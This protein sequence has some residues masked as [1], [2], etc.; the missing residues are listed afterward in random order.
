MSPTDS[1]KDRDRSL[2][3]S[4]P[5][6]GD[7]PTSAMQHKHGND[8]SDTNMQ[9]PQPAK[10]RHNKHW[11]LA[12]IEWHDIDCETARCNITT[13][14]V[15]TAASFVETAADLYTANLVEHFTDPTARHWLRNYWQPEELQHGLAL[16]TYVETVWPEL[17]W[18]THYHNFFAEYSQLCTM[19]EL[20]DSP[21]LEMVA[22][23]VVEAGT[24][25][26]YAALQN[27]SDDPVLKKITGLISRDEV[28]HYNH[29]RRFFKAYQKQ[30]HIG[31]I[32]VVRSLYR[33]LT[34]VENEDAYIGLKHAWLMRHPDQAF[35]K[36]QF[37]NLLED[38]RPMLSGHYP[39]RMAI[40]MLL[41]PLS[42]NRTMVK[43]AIPLLEQA[44]RRLMFKS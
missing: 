43:L 26:F 10:N 6:P 32:G 40:K 42:L 30:E 19:E 16:R 11:T 8:T 1:S 25:T 39:Y 17:D 27:S 7:P 37:D 5:R 2:T 28:S 44:A 24:S 33:R 22:R 4:F 13:Y 23:C 9:A 31:R 12:D 20:E 21:A 3:S 15:V 14:Y 35:N 36:A 41:K 29:F 38:L 18:P 34:E